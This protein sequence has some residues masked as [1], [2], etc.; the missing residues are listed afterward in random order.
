MGVVEPCV[1]AD[2][3]PEAQVVAVYSVGS[4]AGFSSVPDFLWSS[5]YRVYAFRSLCPIGSPHG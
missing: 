4:F 3:V 2:C 1:G 5:V